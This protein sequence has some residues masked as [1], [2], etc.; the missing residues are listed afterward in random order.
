MNRCRPSTI[1][2]YSRFAA[3]IRHARNQLAI[4]R[5]SISDGTGI[6][7]GQ[8]LTQATASSMDGSSQIQ[9]PATKSPLK[10]P[11]TTLRASPSKRTRLPSL[12]GRNPS[13]SRMTPAFLS[14]SLNALI[15]AIDSFFTDSLIDSRVPSMLG[16]ALTKIMNFM[17]G[18][19]V[20]ALDPWRS[21]DYALTTAG[22][23]HGPPVTSVFGQ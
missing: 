15:L 2:A 12:L 11:S 17:A 8:R 18:S 16:F 14:S 4:G 20:D 10:G 23:V 5:I 9:Y 1:P 3:A 19:T 6:A 21:V 13:Q 22:G 7:F